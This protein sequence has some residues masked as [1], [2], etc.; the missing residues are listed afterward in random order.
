MP[1]QVQASVLRADHDHAP[2]QA[3]DLTRPGPREVLV[4]IVAT[5]ICHTDL[6]C[7]DGFAAAPRPVVL[8]HE[9]AGIITEVGDQVTTVAPGDA[10]IMTYWS[11]GQCSRC[12]AGQP[13]YCTDFRA[14]NL[15]GRRPDGTTPMSD[16]NG[17]IGGHFFGQ[18][19]F[20]THSI[21]HERNV[22][23][24]RRDAPL[25]H[26][27]PLGCSGL[28]GAGAV[29]DVIA[30]RPESSLLVVGAGGVGLSAVMAGAALGLPEIVVVEPRTQRR[31]L[32]LQVGAT[33][34]LSPDE[35][36]TLD[37]ASIDA[38]FDTVGIPDQLAKLLGA[39]APG[40]HLVLATAQQ[41]DSVLSLPLLSLVGSGVSVRGVRMGGGRA[42]DLIPR[43]VDLH[44]E[45]RFPL[46]AM[47][48]HYP[49]DEIDTA[50]ADL[51]TGTTIKPILLAPTEENS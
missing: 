31:E 48:R 24:V 19:S 6:T 45:G 46:D 11:C 16:A 37:P 39:I 1:P 15:S 28:T 20:A 8:G 3:V 51:E 2:L 22:V 13:A 9:G 17:P 47:A 42:H 49:L 44:I 14:G 38:V 27:A 25:Q 50:M 10:V 35:V 23:R 18:S 26:L 43:L 41:L 32:A 4:R 36:P 12:N 34:A 33:R 21:A 29:M 40:G 30:A 7:R 5:G